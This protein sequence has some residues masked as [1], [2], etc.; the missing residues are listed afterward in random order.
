MSFVGKSERVPVRIHRD[1][2]AHDLFI[3]EMVLPYSQE[4]GTGCNIL[5]HGVEL[6]PMYVPLHTVV[7]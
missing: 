4:S 2:G 1:T 6:Q 5:V 7:L 3:S